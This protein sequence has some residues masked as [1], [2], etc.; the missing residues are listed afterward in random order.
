MGPSCTSRVL[1]D[2]KG[3]L[4]P[5][6]DRGGICTSYQEDSRLI[7]TTR[8]TK[9]KKEACYMRQNVYNAGMPPLYVPRARDIATQAAR[10]YQ[11]PC[12]YC[13][14][15]MYHYSFCGVS[16]FSSVPGTI[17]AV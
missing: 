17:A 10:I 16:M 8:K 9:T 1:V 14:T 6:Q 7:P 2:F 4:P 13:W 12:T 15:I 5:W 11:V 3:A